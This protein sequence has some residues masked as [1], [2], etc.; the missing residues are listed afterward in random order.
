[1]ALDTG[2]SNSPERAALHRLRSTLARMKA[3][4]ELAEADGTPAQV[5]RL[6]KDVEEAFGELAIAEDAGAATRVLVVDDDQRLAEVTARG[7]RRLGFDAHASAA[8]RALRFG[9][10]LVVDLGL[11]RNLDDAAMESVRMM[12]PVIVTGGTDRAARALGERVDASD[13]LVKPVDLAELKEAIN[14]RKA[15]G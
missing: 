11:L 3:E 14:R 13:Y 15:E 5:E 7:L 12:R 1:M 8:L 10:V 4:L 9:E 6:L 2:S